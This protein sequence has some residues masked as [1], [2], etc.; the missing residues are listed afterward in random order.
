MLAG[1]DIADIRITIGNNPGDLT[2]FNEIIANAAN[3]N[4]LRLRVDTA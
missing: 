3:K 1:K 4:T 2:V